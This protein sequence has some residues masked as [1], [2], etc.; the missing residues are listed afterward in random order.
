MKE[1]NTKTYKIVFG[2][3]GYSHLNSLIENNKYS[4]VSVLVDDNTEKF[5]LDVFKKIINKEII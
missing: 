1:I 4:K 5:C 3:F 2:K